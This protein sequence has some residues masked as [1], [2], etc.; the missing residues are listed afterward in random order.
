MDLKD[1]LV[2]VG[3]TCAWPSL[4]GEMDLQSCSPS[5]VGQLAVLGLRVCNPEPSMRWGEKLR[6]KQKKFKPST[7][8]ENTWNSISKL[9]SDLAVNRR[10]LGQLLWENTYDSEKAEGHS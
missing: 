1:G 8:Q 7:Y 3:V 10:S 4:E 9:I 2:A 6:E 5:P